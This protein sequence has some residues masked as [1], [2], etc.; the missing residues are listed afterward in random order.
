MDTIT[1]KQ[2]ILHREGRKKSGLIGCIDGSDVPLGSMSG[3]SWRPDDSANPNC[4]C[5]DCRALWDP[6]GTIDL[7]LIQDG[8]K[9]AC[10]VYS[11]LLPSKKEMLMELRSKSDDA[12]EDFV[13]A[14]LEL[15]TAMNDVKKYQKSYEDLSKSYSA[16]T[17]NQSYTFLKMYEVE[18]D[19]IES[20]MTATRM[21][22]RH[23]KNLADA[24]EAK[25]KNTEIVFSEARKKERE[26]FETNF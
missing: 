20:D 25:V 23:H 26:F 4:F 10:Y 22:I 13:K 8:N 9:R 5:H 17:E 18:I 16:L 15:F 2:I 14:Q 24:A 1:T 6:D 11:S 3:I 7:K 12:L 21:R 19:K